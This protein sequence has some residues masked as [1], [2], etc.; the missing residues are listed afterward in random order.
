MFYY[1]DANGETQGPISKEQAEKLIAQGIIEPDWPL[2]TADGQIVEAGQIGSFESA[3][4]HSHLCV[5]KPR[6]ES[7]GIFDIHFT[8]F[9]SNTWNSIFWVIT[10]IAHFLAALGATYYSFKEGSPAVFLIALFAVPF[11]LLLH[12]LMF[13]LGIVV[14][15]IESNTRES[16]ECLREIKELL[17]Q[18]KHVS[19]EPEV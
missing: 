13:E 5:P 17:A 14:F 1:F 4:P 11:S 12:R 6:A 9:I 15:R 2:E 3:D 10:I 8:R 19:Q 7:P 16:K 18:N